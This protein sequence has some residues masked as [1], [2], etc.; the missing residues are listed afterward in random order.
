M[1]QFN[2]PTY[3]VQRPTGQCA[4]TGRQLQPGESYIAT[5]VE[6]SDEQL[7]ESEDIASASLGMKRLDV[8]MDAWQQGQR[9]DNLFSFWKTTVPEPNQKKKLFVD[10]E[11]LMSLFRRLD[12][13][14]DEQKL[15][16]RF[17]L[18]LILMR[19][20]LLR[21]E[22]SEKRPNQGEQG[23]EPIVEEWWRM[24]PRG[25]GEPMLLLNPHMNEQRIQQVTEQLGQV[26]EA[27]L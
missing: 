13:T 20:K 22:G 19:K 6:L 1:S 24:Q 16:F 15:C 5:L 7:A 25:G 17:V 27:E 10:D 14:S 11:V 26:L 23:A 18:G 9:P 3:D 12:D 8:S 21:Y 2:T 4:F